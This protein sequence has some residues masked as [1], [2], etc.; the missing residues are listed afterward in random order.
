MKKNKTIKIIR[1]G[2][3]LLKKTEDIHYKPFKIKRNNICF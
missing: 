3:I 1:K 2:A